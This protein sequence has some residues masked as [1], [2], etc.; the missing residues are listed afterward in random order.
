MTKLEWISYIKNHLSR[1]DETNKY[2]SVVIEKNIDTVYSQM[3][4]QEYMRNKSGMYKY[5][6]DYT[7]TTVADFA[8][9]AAIAIPDQ[10]VILPRL[11][12][13]M[14]DVSFI[15]KRT[16]S[17]ANVSTVG[18]FAKLE[19]S[20]PSGAAIGDIVVIT[21]SSSYNG[22]TQIGSVNTDPPA[23]IVITEPFAGD[24]SGTAVVTFNGGSSYGT[25]LTAR[26]M[27]KRNTVS[28]YDTIGV[29]GYYLTTHY[30]ESIYL[31]VAVYTG[32]TITYTILPKFSTL[33]D[34]DEVIL[35]IGAEE[36]LADR[37]LD[38]MRMIPP[39]DLTNDN[40]DQTR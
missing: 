8:A 38:T 28:R 14:F 5:L 27:Y 18:G 2:H 21:G 9:N 37:V 25:E 23:G 32:S 16:S 30:N 22:T 40:A 10:D 1:I 13:G 39:V 7:Y 15:Q 4:S 3:F 33:S 31:P 20:N 6:K 11:N 35:P 29:Q 34:T 36:V 26:D 24:D 12:G 19:G 17:F